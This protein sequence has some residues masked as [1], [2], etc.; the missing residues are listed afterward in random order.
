MIA[1]AQVN[2]VPKPEKVA[3]A[4]SEFNVIV[5]RIITLPVEMEMSDGSTECM[6]TYTLSTSNKKIAQVN[7]AGQVKGVK[8][9]CRIPDLLRR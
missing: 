8:A 6:T 5:G 2:I 9:G 3:I 4:G 1:C 7:D